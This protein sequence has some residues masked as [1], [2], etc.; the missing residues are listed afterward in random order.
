MPQVF[1]DPK[2]CKG[3]GL[4]IDACPKEILARAHELSVRGIYPA[5]SAAPEECIGCM[6]CVVVCPD[7]AITIT[8]DE[9]AAAG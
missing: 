8:D 2:R 5:E 3:C 6:N 9:I 1:I 7:A 4:C